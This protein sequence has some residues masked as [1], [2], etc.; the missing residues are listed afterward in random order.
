MSMTP[1]TASKLA[2]MIKMLSSDQ[3]GDVINAARAIVRTLNNAGADIHEFAAQVEGQKLS[4]ADMQRIYDVAFENGKNAAAVDKGFENT[5]PPI[6]PPTWH[7]MATY[8]CDHDGGRLNE[9]ERK[10]IDD[11]VGWT[12]YREPSEKQRKWLHALYCKLRRR[13]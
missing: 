6:E 2:K 12:V 7:E 4:Q 8:C 9:K 5:E 10:F 3:E 1:E 13:R 11:M